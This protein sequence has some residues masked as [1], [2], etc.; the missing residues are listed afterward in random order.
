MSTNIQNGRYY[1]RGVFAFYKAAMARKTALTTLGR[2][3][4]ARVGG[5]LVAD[6]IDK[7]ALHSSEVSTGHILQR[8][9][10]DMVR[11]QR[12]IAATGRRDPEV[13]FSLELW[14]F[15]GRAAAGR[16]HFMIH[17]ENRALRSK[18]DAMRGVNDFAWWDSTDPPEEVSK[19]DWRHRENVWSRNLGETGRPADRCMTLQLFDGDITR[20]AAPS[21]FLAAIPEK[22]AR[23]QR[24]ARHLAVEDTKDETAGAAI[25]T[26][27]EFERNEKFRSDMIKKATPLVQDIEMPIPA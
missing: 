17:T 3:E 21:D 6:A 18:V 23:I 7:A 15:P 26:L 22:S 27:M 14:I 11:R 5:I 24:L 10:D 9:Y 13:D 25:E 16:T 8:T 19:K 12:A 1:E 4:I 20:H 2:N